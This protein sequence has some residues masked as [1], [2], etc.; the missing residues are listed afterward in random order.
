MWAGAEQPV[1]KGKR[2]S[3]VKNVVRGLNFD[4]GVRFQRRAGG[5][6]LWK[7]SINDE[8]LLPQAAIDFTALDVA[9]MDW[10]AAAHCI[11]G[12][13]STRLVI[14]LNIVPIAIPGTLGA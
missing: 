12:W 3:I 8:E 10:S 13:T 6:V 11:C 14:S 4:I 9:R 1:K 7:F 5:R 2:Y